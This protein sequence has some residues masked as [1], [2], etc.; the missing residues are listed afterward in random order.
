MCPAWQTLALK[1]RFIGDRLSRAF[2]AG[3]ATTEILGRCPRLV[4]EM[5]PIALTTYQFS[6]REL[7]PTENLDRDD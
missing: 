6:R 1:A 4:D 5:T 7:I 3:G 2:S